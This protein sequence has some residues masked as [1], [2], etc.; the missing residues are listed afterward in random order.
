MSAS[1]NTENSQPPELVDDSGQEPSDLIAVASEQTIV[2]SPLPPPSMLADY[3]AV[4]PDLIPW[5]TEH[6]SKEQQHRHHK[7]N[8]SHAVA[9]RSFTLGHISSLAMQWVSVVAFLATLGF[10]LPLIATGSA[11]GLV[12]VAILRNAI[13][14]VVNKLS[15]K[16]D[17]EPSDMDVQ[18]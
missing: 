2:T 18:N 16:N 12:L 4:D 1:Q 13:G 15:K 8:L 7:D 5:I 10:G 3:K 11:A 6:A 9:H 14:K 17:T